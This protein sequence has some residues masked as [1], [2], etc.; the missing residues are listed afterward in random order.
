MDASLF[1]SPHSIYETMG[2]KHGQHEKGNEEMV[3]KFSSH[4][5]RNFKKTEADLASL[6]NSNQNGFVSKADLETI[7][8]L[9]IK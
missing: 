4:S 5:T 1:R 2:I 7:K 8:S 3:S 9:E 6:Y